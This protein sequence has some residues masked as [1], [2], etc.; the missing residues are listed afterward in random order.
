MK[1]CAAPPARRSRDAGRGAA[2][3]A[4]PARFFARETER[5]AREL[6]GAVLECRTPE[7]VASG[8]IVETEAYLGEH[9]AACHAAAGLTPRTAPLYGPPGTAYVYFVYGMHWC[10]NAVTRAPGLPSAVLIRA[11]EPLDGIALMRER[12]GHPRRDADLTSGP[13]R[14]CQA[15]GID[16]R[17]NARPLQRPPLLIRAGTPV[18]DADVIVTPRI[19]IREAAD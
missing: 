6:L 8:R 11:L 14:L 10:V 15:L 4:L 12:R 16:R 2:R 17:H 18:A 13:A 3:A 7:G 19:G 5:V 1:T 9:D